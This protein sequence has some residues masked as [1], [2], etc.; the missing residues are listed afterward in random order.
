ML[1]ISVAVKG[2]STF[3]SKFMI[4]FSDLVSVIC[5][6]IITSFNFSTLYDSLSDGKCQY[7]RFANA[8][9]LDK[10]LYIFKKRDKLK[11]RCFYGQEQVVWNILMDR[12]EKL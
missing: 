5:F 11:N 2:L 6:K 4:S 3:Q 9:D 8:L 12:Y 10:N 7:K 1:T